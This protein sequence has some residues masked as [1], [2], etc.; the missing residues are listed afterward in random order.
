MDLQAKENF[1][2]A[3]FEA[4]RKAAGGEGQPQGRGFCRVVGSP[5]CGQGVVMDGPEEVTSWVGERRGQKAIGDTTRDDRNKLPD[6][7]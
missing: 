4:S 3:V 7:V 2:E 5:P 1:I 6:V